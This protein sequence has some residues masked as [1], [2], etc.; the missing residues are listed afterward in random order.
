MIELENSFLPN[1]T[2]YISFWK[3]YVEDTISF[4]KIG[5]TEFIISVLNS[6]DRKIQF[7][8]QEENNEIIYYFGH[9]TWWWIR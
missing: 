4:L 5:K 1:L 2:K 7:K 3:C 9:I 8:F 6:F